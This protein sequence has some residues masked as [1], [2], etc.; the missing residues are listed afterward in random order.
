M[1]SQNKDDYLGNE[2]HLNKRNYNER[3]ASVI[4]L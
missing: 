4:N 1:V 2:K 3:C